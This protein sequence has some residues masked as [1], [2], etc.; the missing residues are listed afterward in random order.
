MRPPNPALNE[1]E[2]GLLDI[3]PEQCL[4]SA[5]NRG[6]ISLE[7]FSQDL[8]AGAAAAL[9]SIVSGERMLMGRGDVQSASVRSIVDEPVQGEETAVRPRH[10]QWI[11]ETL[12]RPFPRLAQMVE[13]ALLSP[14]EAMAAAQAIDGV[15]GRYTTGTRY[16]AP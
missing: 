16:A 11:L 2:L 3:A 9:Q 13:K 7:E 10:E 8:P 4:L 15:L 1:E 12:S 6:A 5:V 14:D